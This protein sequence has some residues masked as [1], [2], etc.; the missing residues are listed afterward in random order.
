MPT[1]RAPAVLTCHASGAVRVYVPPDLADVVDVDD[2]FRLPSILRTV[3]GR[4]SRQRGRDT[5]WAWQPDWS[6]EPGLLVRLYAHGGALGWLTGTLFL[7]QRRMLSELRATL[8][9]R[10]RGVPSC[11]PVALRVQRICGALV[12]AHLV[13]ELIP[14]AVD[15]LEYLSLGRPDAASARCIASSVAD[16]IAAMHDAGIVHAD[17]NLK[18]ILVRDDPDSPRAFVID[19]DKARIVRNLSLRQRLRNL[20]RLDRSIAKWSASRHAVS[21]LDRLR[22]L[23]CYLARY[24][25]WRDESSRIARRI[26][27]GHGLHRLSRQRD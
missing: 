25:E 20:A 22:T 13:V 6:P 5:V 27:A 21:T 4:A 24:P 16:A 26:A 19:F 7:S 11:R 18:N 8:H 12:R 1:P 2:V 10:S 15:L 9:A 17:L 3:P 23:R 14:D